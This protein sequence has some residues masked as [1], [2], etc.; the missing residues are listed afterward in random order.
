M[1]QIFVSFGYTSTPS[2]TL[3]PTLLKC[4]HSVVIPVFTTLNYVVSTQ[5]LVL[6]PESHAIIMLI[7]TYVGQQLL[8]LIHRVILPLN[9]KNFILHFAG[10]FPFLVADMNTEENCYAY[11]SSMF[12]DEALPPCC[13]DDCCCGAVNNIICSCNL[14]PFYICRNGS[15]LFSGK[16]C[17]CP[18]QLC[19]CIRNSTVMI[20]NTRLY[21]AREEKRCC[22]N[23]ADSGVCRT[24]VQIQEVI[25]GGKV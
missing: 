11:N 10:Q 8:G 3:L 12:D 9:I 23:T 24:L 17:N 22:L 19:I 15:H 1:K 4:V 7:P 6:C 18:T 16:S 21:Y 14:D 20:N 25:V 13:V 2:V 5:P